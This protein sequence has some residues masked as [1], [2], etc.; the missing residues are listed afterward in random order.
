MYKPDGFNRCIYSLLAVFLAK[1]GLDTCSFL[2]GR[3]NEAPWVR[4]RNSIGIYLMLSGY[5]LNHQTAALM[6][7]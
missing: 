2:L 7:V 5:L 4:L 3:L 1:C 6:S